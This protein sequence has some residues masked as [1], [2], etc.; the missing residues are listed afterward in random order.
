MPIPAKKPLVRPGSR[1]TKPE[2]EKEF[3]QVR[4]EVEEARKQASPRDEEVTRFHETEVRQAVEGMTAESV[5]QR[6]SA[7][8]VDIS[9]ALAGVAEQI[10]AEVNR[11]AAAREA[12]E[13][14]KR[15]LERL[16]R[17]DIAGAALEQM[18]QDFERR[19]EELERE[20][21]SRRA[22]WEE[23]ARA[24]ERERKEQEEALRKQRQREIDDYEYRKSLERKKAQDKYDEEMRLLEKKNQEKQEALEKAWK[25]REAA[26]RE[27]EDELA[28]LRKQVEEFP[29]RLQKEVE[30]ATA[31]AA[32]QAEARFQQQI[33]VQQKDAEA[34][35]RVAQ[36][37]VKALEEIVANQA[38]QL[39][40]LQKQ[41]DE[42]KKQVQDIAL[43]AIE[44]AS[45]SRALA[46]INEIAMEQAKHRSGQS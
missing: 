6:I 37:R 41:I 3:E 13:L 22:A 24:A 30:R 25:Q 1:R 28:G 5:V 31:E 29:Q 33:L 18:V 35:G 9:R 26:L 42:A 45:G 39:A 14:E 32:R 34:E 27:R 43:K 8:N 15:E 38:A 17:I 7:L 10:T 4:A 44:G 12:V 46:H 20:I 40:T 2:V 11:L 21:A 19:R 36:L 23:E 16:H